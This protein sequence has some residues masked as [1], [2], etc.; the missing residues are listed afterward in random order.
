MTTTMTA[1][2]E[3][4]ITQLKETDD[5]EQVL[6]LLKLLDGVPAAELPIEELV[7]LLLTTDTSGNLWLMT[8]SM[9]EAWDKLSEYINEDASRIPVEPVIAALRHAL[10]A[11]DTDDEEPDSDL[12]GCLEQIVAFAV[13]LEPFPPDI[14]AGLLAHPRAF[15]RL[16]GLDALYQMD[17]EPEIV[18]FLTD[19]DVEVRAWV[20]GHA[21]KYLPLTTMAAL[22]HDPEEAVRLAAERGVQYAQRY[23][24][25]Q[26][27]A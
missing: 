4:L 26:P 6:C 20:V 7:D 2:A 16:S 24:Q 25:A 5:E 1:L 8:N 15:V 3:N 10:E 14:M 18:P 21:W 27:T 12:D 11:V 19:P 22:T 17:R 13:E 9:Q 23:G